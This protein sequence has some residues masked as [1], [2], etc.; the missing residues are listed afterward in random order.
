M[1]AIDDPSQGLL[2]SMSLLSPLL[3]NWLSDVFDERDGMT[4]NFSNIF[5]SL[6]VCVGVAVGFSAAY[7]FFE[8][9]LLLVVSKFLRQPTDTKHLHFRISK[10]NLPTIS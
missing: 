9:C 10:L 5:S 6:C 2:L 1:G 3:A 8:P 4:F 7:K